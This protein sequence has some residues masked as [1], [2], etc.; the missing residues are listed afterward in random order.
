VIQ[1]LKERQ[2]A[3][4][5]QGIDEHTIEGKWSYMDVIQKEEEHYQEMTKAIEKEF[6]ETPHFA[7]TTL[8]GRK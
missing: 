2:G 7:N 5:M 4:P 3:T 1:G 8:P 6:E